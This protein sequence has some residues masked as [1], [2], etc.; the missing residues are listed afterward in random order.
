[1]V[2][3]ILFKFV[4]ENLNDVYGGYD[5]ALKSA[6]QELRSVIAVYNA[7]TAGYEESD[8]MELKFPLMAVLEYNGYKLLAQSLLPLKG[9]AYHPSQAAW[10]LSTAAVTT[11]TLAR[12]RTILSFLF[13]TATAANITPPPSPHAH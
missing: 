2:K 3:N 10:P 4:T 11:T 13:S 8:T 1:M 12:A 7:V 9:G 5:N 6:N